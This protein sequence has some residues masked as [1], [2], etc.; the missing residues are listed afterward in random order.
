MILKTSAIKPYRGTTVLTHGRDVW[1]PDAKELR[2]NHSFVCE[3]MSRQRRWDIASSCKSSWRGKSNSKLSK[4]TNWEL[5]LSPFISGNIEIDHC[6][7]SHT[8]DAPRDVVVAQ[9]VARL[10]CFL[11]LL[12]V[13][14]V[15]LVLLVLVLVVGGDGGG[16]GAIGGVASV[17][18]ATIWLHSF[19]LILLVVKNA[20]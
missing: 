10:L 1:M 20:T 4:P 17:H 7:A 13:V 19:F 12:L 14:V 8:S 11:L 6:R 3:A 15:L 5:F 18:L 16:G 2:Q 9:N